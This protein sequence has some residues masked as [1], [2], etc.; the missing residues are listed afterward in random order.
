MKTRQEAQSILNQ[1]AQARNVLREQELNEHTNSFR[2][3]IKIS[4]SAAVDMEIVVGESVPTTATTTST[5]TN[6]LDNNAANNINHNFND[7]I[8]KDGNK[9]SASGLSLLVTPSLMTFD[10]SDNLNDTNNSAYNIEMPQSLNQ[11]RNAGLSTATTSS[12]TTNQQSD[13]LN[14]QQQQQR[15]DS[16][17]ESEHFFNNFNI[18]RFSSTRRDLD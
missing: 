15:H 18:K 13:A 2:P 12:G 16:D 14:Q 3:T 10:N 5:T 9:I 11:D 6:I 1:I 17:S 4:N 7:L 8:T